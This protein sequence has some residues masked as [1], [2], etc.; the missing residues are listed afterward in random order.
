MTTWPPSLASWFPCRPC[1]CCPSLASLQ[2]PTWNVP[3]LP[4]LR[5]VTWGGCP[6]PVRAPDLDRPPWA[7]APR[8]RVGQRREYDADAQHHDV[9]AAV[10]K[11]G[12]RRVRLQ[13][14]AGKGD[15]PLDP[16]LR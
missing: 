12:Q 9:K 15:D 11:C 7:P 4:P 8:L 6:A 3:P 14:E 10:A 13:A 16:T 5:R 1:P 2:V